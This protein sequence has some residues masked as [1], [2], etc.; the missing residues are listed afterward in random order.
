MEDK[1]VE[2]LGLLEKDLLGI[3]SA[4]KHLSKSQ[5]AAQ[6]LVDSN[7]EFASSF[8]EHMEVLQGE[9]KNILATLKTDTDAIT[10]KWEKLASGLSDMTDRLGKLT[11]YFESV[12][13]PARLDRVDTSIATIQQGI[14]SNQTLLN[15]IYRK[16]DQHAEKQSQYSNQLIKQAHQLKTFAIIILGL[17]C[18]DIAI[19]LFGILIK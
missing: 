13:F 10:D 7:M 18:V 16:M 5:E 11:T 14:L 6:A 3:D 4:V 19:G 9:I 17:V 2:I 12:N 8:R 15:D 1:L